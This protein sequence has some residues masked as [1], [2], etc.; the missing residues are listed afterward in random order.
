MGIL[1]Q[2][3]CTNAG[4]YPKRTAD[5]TKAPSCVPKWNR[6]LEKDLRCKPAENRNSH[7][8]ALHKAATGRCS[9]TPCRFRLTTIIP[10]DAADRSS[11]LLTWSAKIPSGPSGSLCVVS[12][13]SGLRRRELQ[14][15]TFRKS[16]Q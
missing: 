10:L 16:V 14:R 15:E 12:G 3:A 5:V 8:P 2:M 9:Q 11:L 13:P 1:A 7:A 6:L 4:M